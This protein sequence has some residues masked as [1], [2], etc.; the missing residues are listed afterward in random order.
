MQAG[1][2][3]ANP[4]MLQV[5]R[6]QLELARVEREIQAARLQGEAPSG[7]GGRERI[8]AGPGAGRISG[9]AA[10]RAEV[11]HQFD[12]AQAQVLEETGD[13]GGD[14]RRLGVPS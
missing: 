12:R 1:R 5:Q 14:V 9:L 3:A 7:G 2:E 4:A 13:R 10:R 6:L 11:K 8:S